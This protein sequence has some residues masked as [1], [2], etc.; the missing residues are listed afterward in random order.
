VPGRPCRHARDPSRMELCRRRKLKRSRV[1]SIST[2]SISTESSA[3]I[4]SRRRLENAPSF[5]VFGHNL[6]RQ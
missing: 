4:I 2:G 6:A 1:S 3:T 5:D